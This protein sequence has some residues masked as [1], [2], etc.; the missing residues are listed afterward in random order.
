MK[1]ARTFLL[2]CILSLFVLSCEKDEPF[3]Q[4][5]AFETALHNYVSDYRV[6]QGL[7]K[8]VWFPDIFIEAREQSIAWKKS[9]DA[10]TGI[11]E[12]LGIIQDHWAPENLGVIT[13]SFIGEAD[14]TH[15]R[16]VVNAWIE[17]PTIDS[18]LIDDFVQSGAGI[19]KSDDVV[20][21]THFLMK[22]VQK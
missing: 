21:I 15:A 6:T 10:S 11:N 22:V 4:V 14:T 19:A 2:I 9:G 3:Y 20:Y 5:N 13:S 1:T 12:R 16:L 8:L 7:N 17:D 18:I